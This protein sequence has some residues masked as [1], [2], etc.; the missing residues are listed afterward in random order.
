[1]LLTLD[2]AKAHAR[3]D[4]IVEDAD[5]TIKLNGAELAAVSYLNRNVYADQLALDAAIADVPAALTAARTAYE[6]DMSAAELIENDVERS[7][8][9]LIAEEKY[10]KVQTQAKRTYQGMVLND[11][12][13]AG[14]LL[15]FG[16]LYANR[17][18]VVTG[19]SVTAL[20]NGAHALLRPYRVLSI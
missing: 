7:F 10:C 13:R 6:S 9:E 12:V 18:D 19:V 2:Q 17:E 1:M 15:I 3:I 5:I 16:H 11:H 4:G 14:I 8:A 20:P